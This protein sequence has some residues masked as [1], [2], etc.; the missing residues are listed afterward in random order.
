MKIALVGYG[1]MG[2]ALLSQWQAA[3]PSS[4]PDY[5]FVVIDPAVPPTPQG[6]QGLKGAPVF[7]NA[8]P[9]AAD[10]AF[11]LV[12]L[13]VKPQVL[14]VVAPLYTERL[15]P[16]GFVASIAAGSSIARLKSLTGNA[17]I[18]R[19]M[20]N[21]PAAIGAGASGLCA[22][23]TTDAAQRGMVESL[24]RAVGSVLWVDDED[25]LDRLTAI[26]GSGPGY[27]FEIARTYTEAAIQLGFS[28]DAAKQLV[29]DTMAGTIEMARQSPLSLEDL[30]ESVTSKGGTTAAG[31]DALNGEG[32]LDRL[33][34][35]T[36]S[37]AYA[38]AV[39]L[40]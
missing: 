4:F 22:D 24:M 36:L 8:P 30:R 1:K 16:G 32:E 27:V 20:P 38:R 5:R 7:L 23:P 33:F 21:L 37:A 6:L 34:R 9:A 10:S 13:A 40:R 25:Q 28:P 17:P 35:S 15:A 12:I 26:A 39:A 14:D 3:S 11:D 19:I 18:V 29:L 31:L 2:T